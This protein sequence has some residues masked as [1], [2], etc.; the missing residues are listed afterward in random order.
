MV[1]SDCPF[2]EPLSVSLQVNG[3]ILPVEI[4]TGEAVSI[5]SRKSA[6]RAVSIFE[7]TENQGTTAY[8]YGR[9]DDSH[10]YYFCGSE[11]IRTK[12][13]LCPYLQ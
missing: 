6:P 12:L 8:L 1:D 7:T 13:G 5:I 3:V 10:G 9:A 2:G 4:D 11:Y